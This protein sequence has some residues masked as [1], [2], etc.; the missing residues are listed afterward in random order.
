MSATSFGLIRDI[1]IP[2]LNLSFQ[3]YRHEG[4]GARH[5][6][7]AT[8][9]T[10]NAFLVAFLTVPQDSTGV[11]HILEHTSLC[12]SKRF[13]VRDPFFMMIRRSLNTFMNAFTASDWTAYPF[14]SQ[15][16]K[17]FDNLLEVYLDA[18]FFPLLDPMD[19]AQEGH[20]VEFSVPADSNSALEYKGVVYNE[21]KG[22]M[23]SPVSQ[24]AQVLQSKLFPTITYHHN[25]G[26]DPDAI[27]DLSLAGLKSFHARHYHPSNAVF[28]TY[29]SFS[30]QD[31][32]ERMESLVL[33]H[34]ESQ[35]MNL[36]IG[37]EQ[38]FASPREEQSVYATDETDLARKSHVLLGWLLGNS[39]DVYASMQARLLAGVLLDNSA[40]P[41]RHALETTGLG[42]APSELCGLD[43]STRE[44]T[45]VCGLEG[46]EGADANAIE[47]LV[48]NT[49][50]KLA[51]DGVDQS[52]IESVVHQVELAQRE[53]SG[54]GFP[55]GL[56]LMVRSLSPALYG[57]DPYAALDI[58]PVLETLR[59]E[60]KDPSYL[61]SLIREL[62]L[63]N[64]HRIRLTMRPDPTLI[65]QRQG[66]E[67]ERLERTRVALSDAERL[68]LIE[69][70]EALRLRQES[71]DNPEVLPKVTIED[72]PNEL[73]IPEP[74][75]VESEPVR[76]TLYTPGTN[77]LVYVQLVADLPS[78]DAE[79]LPLLPIFCD[80]LA[81]VGCG[82]RDYLQAQEWQAAVT[83]GVRA[84]TSVR[85]AV[86]SLAHPKGYFVLA[87]KA[88]AR[89]R[90]GLIELLRETFLGA[91]FDELDRLRELVAQARLHAEAQVT[92]SGHSL[93]MLAAT[94]GMSTCAWLEHTWGGLE[95]LQALKQL[96][97]Q[98]DSPQELAALGATLGRL[99]EQLSASACEVMLVC[100]PGN[101]QA[102]HQSLAEQ[103][104]DF[105]SRSSRKLT[106]G[107]G[108]ATL[109][110]GFPHQFPHFVSEAWTTN[111]Q[112]NFC[113]Q[114]FV[115]PP[116]AHADAPALR[117][118]GGFLRNSYLHRAIREQGGAYGSG[119]GYSPDSGSFRFYSYRDP[120]LGG[121]LDDFSGSVQW[122][123]DNQHP[124][125]LLEEALLGVVG[126][127]DRPDSPAGEAVIGYFGGLHGRTPNERRQFR[128]AVL[129]VSMADLRRVAETY[130]GNQ[131]ASTAVVT[132]NSALAEEPA[133]EAFTR[134]HI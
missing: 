6:H 61:P 8:D 25:S 90:D 20:R 98:I 34:F 39:T 76:T 111:T 41:L 89:N 32:Q 113:A 47:V 26:G 95:G 92:D 80:F 81:D 127:I 57:G 103:W 7:L 48:L 5:F 56:Q 68:T 108:L 28:M 126:E 30:P 115:A 125:R 82:Q 85:S 116:Q 63:D 105:G 109:G 128:Q 129:D 11:A 24:V 77:G 15:N 40:S 114:A 73:A 53:V 101:A 96:D 106:T 27:P 16:R 71:E 78:L 21:M 120:R 119:A 1:P 64:P 38:R 79:T 86:D 83:G 31:H 58:D 67:H 33:R 70:A 100:D 132:S 17:D 36:R 130:L 3:E 118:L 97:Q 75:Q 44:T 46:C 102:L 62:L 45:F 19:F 35:E 12:G 2:S 107:D 117:V 69:Q 112:V 74:Q 133:L 60:V 87:G 23:S 50:E 29:G 72:V 99:R 65:E 10:N 49:L 124:A 123:L 55:Y 131:T 66:A 59:E 51:K 4:T 43:D 42:T 88:L 104:S 94:A 14:A 84:R 122:L 52:V 37:D 18:A 110:A 134:Y 91:R 93:A 54:G 22:A 13:P 9:D 121:T